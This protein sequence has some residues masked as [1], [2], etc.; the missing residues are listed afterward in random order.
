MQVA[1]SGDTGKVDRVGELLKRLKREIYTILA[2][3][4]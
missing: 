1:R 3:D 2:E 4:D